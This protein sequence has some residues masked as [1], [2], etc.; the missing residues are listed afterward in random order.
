MRVAHYL[1]RGATGLFYVRVRVPADLW[2]PVGAKVI[3]RATGTRCVRAAQALASAVAAAYARSFAAMRAGEPMTKPPNIKDILTGQSG[4]DGDF[5]TWSTDE[6]EVTPSGVRFKGL[7]IGDDADQT[8]FNKFLD[9]VAVMLPQGATPL[10]EVGRTLEPEK[11]EA[12]GF[13]SFEGGKEKW[14][15]ILPSSSP[16]KKKTKR[17]KMKALEDVQA[18]FDA[19]PEPMRP[20]WVRDIT[21]RHCSEL[22]IGLLKTLDRRTVENKFTVLGQFLT[23]ARKSGYL[24]KREGEEG[25]PSDGFGRVSKKDK[26]AANAANG[27][28]KFRPDQLSVIFDH[29]HYGDLSQDA[30]RWL[31]L[32]CLYTGARGNEIAR[33]ELADIY[34]DDL[35]VP[36]FDI[37][38][39]G[40]DKSIKAAASARL[41]PIH[42]DLLALGLLDRVARLKA[43]GEAKL[44]PA[45]TF[46]AQNGPANAP[47]TAFSRYLAA[48]DIKAR[49]TGT[50]GVHSFRDTV[51][52]KLKAGGVVKEVREEYTGHA[53]ANK[54]EYASAYEDPFSTISLAKTCHP[55]LAFGLNIDELR[56]L[57]R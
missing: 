2:G 17:A 7:N 11:T 41:T 56:K 1:V 51:L 37:S 54:P 28:Q 8:R 36:V 4:G 24:P 46:N 55:V 38:W 29:E 43:E 53:S 9:R 20:E 40:D 25:L 18:V 52:N 50:V 57:L 6:M 44:F 34:E 5:R 31:P 3:K 19:F 32:I 14:A 30:N 33:L 10:S 12:N 45:L 23:W 13:I 26:A 15:Q 27:A 47:M 22:E 39:V 21:S 16:A 35:G 49:G 42:S 48:R